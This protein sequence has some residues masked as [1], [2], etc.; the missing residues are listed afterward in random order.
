MQLQLEHH[1][2]EC[3]DWARRL[4]RDIGL[5]PGE[6][7][8]VGDPALLGLVAEA[9]ELPGRADPAVWVTAAELLAAELGPEATDAERA[10]AAAALALEI[11]GRAAAATE[12]WPAAAARLAL[13]AVLER[14]GALL[15][16]AVP[17]RTEIQRR[18]IARALEPLDSLAL[19]AQVADAA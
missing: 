9:L 14:S 6:P 3:R 16:A 4:S 10:L 12:H 5:R 13:D 19:A 1:A 18:L 15:A 11:C 17:E 2:R 8:P 7:V